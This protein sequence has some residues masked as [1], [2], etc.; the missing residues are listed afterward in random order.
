[1][2]QSWPL[3]QE[4]TKSEHLTQDHK[5]LQYKYVQMR[6]LGQVWYVLNWPLVTFTL[7]S[8]VH[9]LNSS[10][11][12]MVPKRTVEHRG[13]LNQVCRASMAT[14]WVAT[15]KALS[16]W[17]K[18]L[19]TGCLSHTYHEVK[20]GWMGKEKILRR[21]V[22]QRGTWH[23]K[24]NCKTEVPVHKSPSHPYYPVWGRLLPSNLVLCWT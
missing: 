2:E 13:K 21:P 5:C 14:L 22:Q 1:M 4:T 23:L 9:C 20:G 19:E 6:Q 24:P 10:T 12:G 11:W 16:H 15:T 18:K 17:K 3:S 8:V 7:S